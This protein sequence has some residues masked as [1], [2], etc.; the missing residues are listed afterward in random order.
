VPSNAQWRKKLS[1]EAYAVLRERATEAPFSGKLLKN[2]KNGMYVCGAC[3]ADLFSSSSKYESTEAGLEGWPSFSEVISNHAVVLKEDRSHGMQ[4]L[5]VICASCKRHLGHVFKA[6]DSPTGI[7]YCINSV[8]LH[9]R[10][11]KQ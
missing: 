10:E 11:D 7:H 5:E 2:T 3:N 8:A 6:S 9:F 4:R 1:P